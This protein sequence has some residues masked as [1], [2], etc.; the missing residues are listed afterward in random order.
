MEEAEVHCFRLLLVSYIQFSDHER[1]YPDIFDGIFHVPVKSCGKSSDLIS[2][3]L[4]EFR[5]T[6]THSP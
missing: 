3:G 4:I 1:D 2:C 5:L 6:S